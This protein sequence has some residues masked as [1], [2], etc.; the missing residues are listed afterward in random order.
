MTRFRQIAGRP[1]QDEHDPNF[2]PLWSPPEESALMR[3]CLYYVVVG[4]MLALAAALLLV[5][6]Q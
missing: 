4:V 5:R 2:D 1:I 3:R 6:L